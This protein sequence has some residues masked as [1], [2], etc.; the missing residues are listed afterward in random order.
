[1]RRSTLSVA[2]TAI[3]ML[4][5]FAGKA[6]SNIIST[7]AGTGAASSTGDGGAATSATLNQPARIVVDA[8]GNKYISDCAGSK[9]RKI[10]ASGIITTFA[11]TGVAGY[12]SDGIAATA[13][14]LSAPVGLALDASGNL[15]IADQNN[16]RIR[17]VN[18]S[19]IISTI[20]GTGVS[21]YTG[22]GGAATAA[23]IKQPGGVAVDGAGNIYIAD[24][25][26]VIRKIN[27]SGNISTVAGTG[28][29]GY[30]GDGGAA[31]A[32][33]LNQPWAI[34]TDAS[35]NLYIADWMN[36]RIRKVNSTSGIITTIAG[37]GTSA[38]TGDG[39]MATTANLNHPEEIHPELF[40]QLP[41]TILPALPGMAG[42]QH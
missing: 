30:S 36:N 19:G 34:T 20:A 6:Q 18:T 32:A 10:D 17:M 4:F 26:H 23:K 31:T 25:N 2:F 1:M 21:G 22:D 7:I 35:N 33:Q 13:A 37:M 12:N 38:Y 5:A 15:Y 11:G 39:G 14:Q 3:A 28:I 9:V 27:T 8:A 41:V 40:P 29:A 24:F 16:H 42:P